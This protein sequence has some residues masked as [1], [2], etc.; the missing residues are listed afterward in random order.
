MKRIL[1]LMLSI[2]TL[3]TSLCGITHA[4]EGRSYQNKI[5]V[6]IDGFDCK[7]DNG[8]VFVYTNPA[9]S[10]YRLIMANEFNFRYTETACSSRRAAT[11]LK[12][13]KL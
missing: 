8:S 13:A 11:F 7:T 12:T 6:S 4:A 5:T 9:G 3:A 2:F 10:G 1:L